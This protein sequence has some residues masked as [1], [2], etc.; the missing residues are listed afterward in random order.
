MAESEAGDTTTEEQTQ[1]KTRGRL[2][3]AVE[4]AIFNPDDVY[5]LMLYAGVISFLIITLF[6]FYWLL[7]LALTPR[8]QIYQV[9]LLPNGFNP[10]AFLA[11]FEQFPF[12]LYVVNSIV[13]ALTTVVIVITLA[14]FAGYA[15][16][17]LDFPFK[18]PLLFLVLLL[19]YFPPVAYII[20]L[21]RLLTGAVSVF[22]ISTPDLYNTPWA[23]AFPFTTLTLPISI[24]ILTTF[25]SQIPDGLEDAARVEGNTRLGA[26]FDVIL[27]LSKPGIVTASIIVFISVYREFFFSFLMTNGQPENWAVLVYGILNFQQQHANLYNLMAAASLIGVFPI[28]LLVLIAQRHIISGLTQ[29]AVRG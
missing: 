21:F 7:V 20:P 24:F 11:V 23:M 29:G 18:R 9:S 25:F 1:T 28:V 6:P 17:R 14:S 3:R 15:F 5:E 8:G 19:S 16:G 22:G 12:H 26:L 10:E 13:I 2:S 4:Y 27:P